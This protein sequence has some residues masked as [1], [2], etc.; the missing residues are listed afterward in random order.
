MLKI[1]GFNKNLN[2]KI[3]MGKTKMIHVYFE[4]PKLH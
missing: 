3:T 2:L 4:M 1:D